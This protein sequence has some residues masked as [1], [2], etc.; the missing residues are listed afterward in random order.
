MWDLIARAPRSAPRAML[1]DFVRVAVEE[2]KHFDLL[3]RRLTVLG[4][5]YG[6]L[7]AHDGLWQAA[8]SAGDNYLA[9]VAIIPLVLEA[10][11]L[12]V[13]PGMIRQLESARDQDSAR[14]L[15]IIYDDEKRHVAFGLKWFRHFCARGQLPLEPTFHRL[16]RTHFRGAIRPPFNDA[17]R[18]Q[19]GLA[20]GF[21]KPLAAFG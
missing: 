5:H 15:T 4:S 8:Q 13:S 14:I 10:R 21:Y 2:A 7:P 17:A 11:G 9:R 1:H 20:P 12:D 3:Q 19:A 16:I 18:A 6:A